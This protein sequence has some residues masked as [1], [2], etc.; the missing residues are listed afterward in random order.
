MQGK[1]MISFFDLVEQELYPESYLPKRYFYDSGKEEFRQAYIKACL[2]LMKTEFDPNERLIDGG[3]TILMYVV[4]TGRLDLVKFLVEAG[5]NV[6]LLDYDEI[7][8]A[9]NEAAECGWK[10]I[11]DYL[12]PLTSS[13]LRLRVEKSLPKD[14]W[15]FN[16]K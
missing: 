11:Y 7:T 14:Y 5:A 4:Q 15:C 8:F 10:E 13:E 2:K 3:E 6:N 12:A 16:K 1:N 9:L